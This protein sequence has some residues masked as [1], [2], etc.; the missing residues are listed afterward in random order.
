MWT[1]LCTPIAAPI[2]KVSEQRILTAKECRVVNI[3]PTENEK[4]YVIEIVEDVPSIFIDS[5]QPDVDV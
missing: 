3:A 1:L 5:K 2:S 4:Q